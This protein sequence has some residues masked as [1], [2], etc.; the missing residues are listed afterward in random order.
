MNFIPFDLVCSVNLFFLELTRRY[1]EKAEN[2]LEK[3]HEMQ[4]NFKAPLLQFVQK[5]R[6]GF[7]CTEEDRK[8]TN[9]EILPPDYVHL[10]EEEVEKMLQ[11]TGDELI[12]EDMDKYVDSEEEADI[13]ELIA[14]EEATNAESAEENTEEEGKQG[15]KKRK[16]QVNSEKDAKKLKTST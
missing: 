15:E 4:R 7:L 6:D 14:L 12:V 11:D 8:M 3:L 16:K 9:G 2:R 5:Y 10:T 13:E 1:Y